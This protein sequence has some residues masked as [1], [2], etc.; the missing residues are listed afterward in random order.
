M[1]PPRPR[2]PFEV[3][4]A[5]FVLEFAIILFDAPAAFRQPHGASEPEDVPGGVGEPMV[6][7]RVDPRGHSK[8]SVTGAAGSARVVVQPWDGHSAVCANRER[9]APFVPCRHVT[10]CHAVAGNRAAIS[11]RVSGSG[12]AAR[13]TRRRARQPFT[14]GATWTQYGSPR[15]VSAARNA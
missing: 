12:N 15:A 6:R 7:R 9:S 1:M 10:G 8:S 11:L 4:E 2:A 13:G 14:L 5:E 3:I